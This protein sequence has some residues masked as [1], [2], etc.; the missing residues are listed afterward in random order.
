[1]T[2]VRRRWLW[3][4]AV[5]L[6]LMA[7]ACAAYI[8]DYYR[9]GDAAVAAMAAAD[10][11]SIADEGGWI[12][13]DGPGE[14]AALAFYPGAKV[15]AEAYAPLMRR[16]CEQGVD[17]Y[18]LRVPLRLALLDSEAAGKPILKYPHTRWF[19]G[20]HSMGGVAAS[21]FAGRHPEMTEGLILLASYPSSAL[22]EGMRLLSVYGS[23]DGVLTLSSY[24]QH[25]SDWPADSQ[26][27]V[28]Q[29]GNHA[30]F[31]D[32]GPQKGDGASMISAEEQQAEA[33]ARIAA[34]CRAA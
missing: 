2:P 30:G 5:V 4:L 33:A 23:L 32:Y 29:G 25:R 10:G 12:T 15:A 19:V 16:I 9:A 22:P 17:A 27:V 11:L 3:A 24:E 13:F 34:F 8:G 6:A 21:W 31:G 20:G 1:M 7:A 14:D 18:L 28:I 26:E